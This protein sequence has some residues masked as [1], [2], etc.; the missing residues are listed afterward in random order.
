ML[1]H[2]LEIKWKRGPLRENWKV[3][4]REVGR[5]SEGHGSLE[6]FAVNISKR[7]DI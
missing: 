2:H 1:F 3:L 7:E 5:K 6:M 4:S